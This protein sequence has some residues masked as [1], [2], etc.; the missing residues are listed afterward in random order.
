MIGNEILGIPAIIENPA[1]LQDCDHLGDGTWS[2]SARLEPG[3]QFPT[4][5]I[6]S[7]QEHDRRSVRHLRI[8]PLVLGERLMSFRA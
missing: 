8:G 6:P 3:A 7:C 4:A 2:K 5:E 1:P